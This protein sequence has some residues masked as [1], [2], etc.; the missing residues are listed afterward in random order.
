MPVMNAC[1]SLSLATALLMAGPAQPQPLHDP[2]TGLRLASYRAPVPGDVPGGR[3]IGLAELRDR[4]AGDA[5]LIDVMAAPEHLLRE[6]G[7]WVL[8]AKHDTIPGAVWLPEIGRGKL[9]ARIAAYLENALAQCDRDRPI[10]VFCRS[11]CW[12]SWNAVQHIAAR[13]FTNI[14]W[15]PGGTDEWHDFGMPLQDI[16]PLPLSGTLCDERRG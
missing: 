6:N 11:D 8:A 3:T 14:E 15:Y 1:I 9:D 4:Q 2:D 16:Q 13:G 5:L 7:T 12:M 10:V